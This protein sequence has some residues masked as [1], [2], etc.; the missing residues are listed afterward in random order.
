MAQEVLIPPWQAH[1]S[2]PPHRSWP[3]LPEPQHQQLNFDW[4]ARAAS[5]ITPCCLCRALG[6]SLTVPTP[7]C[8]AQ[9]L[10]ADTPPDPF[11]L[12]PGLAPSLWQRPLGCGVLRPPPSPTQPLRPNLPLLWPKPGLSLH[13]AEGLEK[14]RSA[15]AGN[16][17]QQPISCAKRPRRNSFL[18]LPLGHP[19]L[20]ILSAPR[21]GPI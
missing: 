6:P 9:A 3:S 19:H 21:P 16:C 4:E 7:A 13:L 5:L 11:S 2:C 8:P 14:P 10:P 17:R 18:Q 12:L 15:T 20:L 1:A